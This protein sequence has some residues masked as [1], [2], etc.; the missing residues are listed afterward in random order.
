M[1][2]KILD[3]IKGMNGEEIVIQKFSVGDQ[4]YI[5][6]AILE[7]QQEGEKA[8]VVFKVGS[9]KTMRLAFGIKVWEGLFGKESINWN[10]SLGE[11]DIQR[12]L[13]VIRNVRQEK[14]QDALTNVYEKLIDFNPKLDLDL[15]K[16]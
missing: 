14:M 8:N 1:D 7:I 2:E 11:Q 15:K 4:E 16:K 5:T 6:N 3:K 9:L 12:R 13:R 10:L